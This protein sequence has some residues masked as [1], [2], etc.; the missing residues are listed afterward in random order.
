MKNIYILLLSTTLALPTLAQQNP[1]STKVDQGADKVEQKVIT[2]RRDF[3]QNPELSNNEKRTAAIVAKHLKALGMEV[4]TGVA[5]TGVVGILKGGKP[6]PVIALRADMDALP[7][8]ERVPLPFASKVKSTYNGQP[9]GVMHACG[10]DSHVAILMGA[11]EVLAGMKNDLS[12]TIKFIFQPAEEGAPFG[13]EGGAELMIKEGVLE[14]PKVD[15]AFGLHINSQTEVGKVT[16]R[17]GGTMASVND[18]KITVKGKQA[19]GAYPWS[20]VDPIVVSA[21]IINNL[22]TIVSRNLNVTENPGIVTIGTIQ[23]GNRSN[24]IPEQVEMTGTLRA[25]SAEDEKMII[26]RVK[27]VATKTAESAGAT[28]EVQIPLSIRYPVTYNQPALT[29]K[30]LPTLQRTAGT[31]NVELRPAVTGA[32]DFSFFQEKVP[33]LFVFLGGMPKGKKREEAPS[34]HTPDFFIDESGFKLGIRALCNLV[35]DYPGKV[36]SGGGN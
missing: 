7:V 28:A 19:H 20:S 33:G 13:E 6:G 26:A 12:G 35:L 36:N 2:W 30:M 15:V 1:L 23:G 10:H 16:Y 3:H 14:N 32:E 25:L 9:V 27:Q 29:E 31:E 34:H 17:P 22:Q 8:T 11:A 5:K 24:I 4:K 21:Q 18:M